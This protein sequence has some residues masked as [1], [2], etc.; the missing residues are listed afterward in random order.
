M[1]LMQLSRQLYLYLERAQKHSL[2]IPKK[3]CSC[4]VQICSS[5]MRGNEKY[6]VISKTKRF[7]KKSFN[8]ATYLTLCWKFVAIFN[9]S[10]YSLPLIHIRAV[11]GTELYPSYHRVGHQFV[12]GQQIQTD[13]HS[14]SHPHLW[15][16]V[17]PIYQTLLI[18]CLWTVEGSW[19]TQ[20][21]NSTLMVEA[22]SG[23]S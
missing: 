10:I 9:P 23:P 4:R 21:P 6:F 14:H 13:N 3:L 22:N 18:A 7:E 19:S 17:S 16:T 20:E 11:G 2:L 8:R 5:N 15:A 1:L 12:T